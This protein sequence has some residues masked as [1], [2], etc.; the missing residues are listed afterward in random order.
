MMESSIKRR[1]GNS[2]WRWL[3]GPPLLLALLTGCGR[4]DVKVYQTTKEPD[5]SPAQA[6]SALPPGHPDV[7]SMPSMPPAGMPGNSPPLLTWKT[8]E[9][10]TEQAPGAMR[11]GSFKATN[12]DG[13]SADISIIPLGGV[14]GGDVANVNRWR[15]QI[16]LEPASADEIKQLAE[17]AEVDGQPAELYDL[18]GKNPGTGAP[19]GILVAFA[20]RGGTSWFFKMTGDPGVIAGQKPAFV[21][22]LKS[23][24]FE[25]PETAAMPPGHPAMEEMGL[26]AGHPDVSTM[27][28]SPETGHSRAMS[29]Q[30]TESR[31]GGSV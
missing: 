21:E 5:Q 29:G 13:K 16:G 18:T 17:K 4:D 6:N 1:S 23:V 27:P 9:S 8:P 24:R 10:W 30:L 19:E 12:A 2:G 11:V 28:Y 14:A 25:T 7:S 15:G 22:F 31:A 20:R 26:P 3:V